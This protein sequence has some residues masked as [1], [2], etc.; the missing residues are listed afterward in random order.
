MKDIYNGI[1]KLDK[2]TLNMYTPLRARLGTLAAEAIGDFNFLDVPDALPPRAIDESNDSFKQ[3][4]KSK[5]ASQ[6]SQQHR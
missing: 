6:G 5:P 1:R 2:D 3:P 4:K